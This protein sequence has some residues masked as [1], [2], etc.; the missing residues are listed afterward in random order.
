M[1][2]PAS[3]GGEANSSPPFHVSQFV[4]DADWKCPRLVPIVMGIV[5]LLGILYPT[6]SRKDPSKSPWSCS[7]CYVSHISHLLT[8]GV[9]RFLVASTGLL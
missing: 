6:K 4:L 1:K 5:D 7:N 9:T 8:E 2:L 3:G